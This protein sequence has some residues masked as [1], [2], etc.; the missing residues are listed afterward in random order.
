MASRTAHPST[1]QALKMAKNGFGTLDSMMARFHFEISKG[2]LSRALNGQSVSEYAENEIRHKLS[3]PSIQT[4]LVEACPDCGAAHTG[5]C[6]GKPVV[7]VVT[8]SG[9]ARNR[10]R[11][12]RP[13]MDDATYE[14]WLQFKAALDGSGN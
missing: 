12:H 8:V 13:C 11:Y 7:R 10:K 6:H 4:V 9:K 5:R 14:R 2:T 1:V 3:L